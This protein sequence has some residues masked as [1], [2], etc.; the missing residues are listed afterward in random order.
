MS[1]GTLELPGTP[2][3]SFKMASKTQGRDAKSV[4]GAS[5]HVLINITVPNSSCSYDVMY[6][7]LKLD[8][9]TRF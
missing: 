6:L 2:Q 9:D 5:I 3:F 1:L 4:V 8:F 7:Y